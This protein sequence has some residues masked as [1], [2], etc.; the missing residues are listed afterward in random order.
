MQRLPVKDIYV[1]EN[2][3][4]MTDLRLY[5]LELYRLRRK[6][7][8]LAYTQKMNAKST[9]VI[10]LLIDNQIDRF[11]IIR[12]EEDTNKKLKQQ[13][14][15]ATPIAIETL[16]QIIDPRILYEQ[17]YAIKIEEYNTFLRELQKY[18]DNF[19]NEFMSYI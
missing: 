2:R 1:L 5:N 16:Q 10:E 11:E 17:E 7:E 13:Y 14:K 6:K 4:E 3:Q 15:D 18:G 19:L 8:L 12:D 9:P